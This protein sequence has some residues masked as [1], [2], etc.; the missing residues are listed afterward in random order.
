MKSFKPIA[1]RGKSNFR[2]FLRGQHG[3]SKKDAEKLLG[4]LHESNKDY[5]VKTL[6]LSDEESE[7]LLNAWKTYVKKHPEVL[8]HS[9][10]R[11]LDS[12]I[13]GYLAHVGFT[14]AK[15]GFATLSGTA[16]HQLGQ[17]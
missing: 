9:T 3:L 17:K 2:I 5:F 12:F 16:S 6:K 8:R 10:F 15:H 4:E 11:S 1:L 13:H 14:R 7:F